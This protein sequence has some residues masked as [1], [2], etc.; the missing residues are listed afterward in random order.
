MGAVTEY[1]LQTNV[2]QLDSPWH[3][4]T[5]CPGVYRM[6]AWARRSDDYNGD[7]MVSPVFFFPSFF[8]RFGL[9]YF[10]FA[11]ASVLNPF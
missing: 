6:T 1:E 5:M 10:E 4:T 9:V 11:L 3:I 7:Q 8:L 2:V